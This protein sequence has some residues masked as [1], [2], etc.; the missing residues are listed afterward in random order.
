MPVLFFSVEEHPD[1]WLSRVGVA[2]AILVSWRLSFI[3]KDAAYSFFFVLVVVAVV[4]LSPSSGGLPVLPIIAHSPSD[5]GARYSRSSW[6]VSQHLK[7]PLLCGHSLQ[8]SFSADRPY[9]RGA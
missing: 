3:E 2:L 5:Y 7:L 9:L 1:F 4:H 8:K 6:S